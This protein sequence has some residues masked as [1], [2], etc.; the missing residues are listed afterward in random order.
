MSLIK[1]KVTVT[2]SNR[3][4]IRVIALVLASYLALQFI[5]NVSNILTLIGTSFFLAVALNPAVSWITRRLKSRSRVAATGIAYIIVL[6]VVIGFFSLI[7]PPLVRQTTDF[8]S[9]VPQIVGG[10]RTQ[11]S[12]LG[13]FVR[14]YNLQQ[15]IDDFSR[16]FTRRVA[17]QARGKVFST[18]TR[19][20]S[21]FV[22]I[23]AVL[24]MTFMM[25]VEGP[26]WIKKFWSLQ[27]TSRRAHNKKLV[28]KMYRI[29]TGYVNG[30]LII[31]L[32]A[33]AFA[34]VAL[35]IASTLL[36]VSIN[37][38]AMAGIIAMTG[39]I[40]MIGNTIGAAIVVMVCLFSSGPLAIIMAIF[41]L[42][43][44]QLENVTIQPYIQAKQ[45]ELTPLLVFIA[46]LLGVGFGGLAG[47]F[48]AIP[49]AGCAKILFE[50]YVERHELVP[51]AKQ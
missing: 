2:V 5:S 27:P 17:P 50:D 21:A 6:T 3:T 24:V 26:A 28:A 22:S 39:L 33:G 46:A 29:V 14:R 49:A 51:E 12:A 40:P 32:L 34:L 13:R 41:F 18:A 11:D 30:Q 35:M 48:I 23:L 1:P 15:D 45:N 47:G 38:I 10:L 25:L 37:P 42:V 4:V 44:Q 9:D 43:Y 8:V 7:L 31:A 19:V 16:D 36:H 20:G